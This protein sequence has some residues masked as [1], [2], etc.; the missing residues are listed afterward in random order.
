M[1]SPKEREKLKNKTFLIDLVE[2]SVTQPESIL[3]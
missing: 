2:L 1:M 3:D